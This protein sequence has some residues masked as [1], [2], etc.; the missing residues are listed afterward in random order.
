MEGELID[1]KLVSDGILTQLFP[2]TSK[3]QPLL[4]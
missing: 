2:N 4:I 1:Y 3:E